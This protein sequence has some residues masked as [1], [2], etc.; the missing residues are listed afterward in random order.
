M[1]RGRRNWIGWL[2]WRG[3][4]GEVEEEGVGC[5]RRCGG[6]RGWIGHEVGLLGRH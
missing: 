2:E 5:M 1:N 6:R 4:V 3:W